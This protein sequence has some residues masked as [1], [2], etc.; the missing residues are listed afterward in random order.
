[1]GR[2]YFVPAL[3]FAVFPWRIAVNAYIKFVYKFG[4]DNRQKTG[5]FTRD[6]SNEVGYNVTNF[7]S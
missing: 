2:V 7:I 3:V 1:M 4:I 6:I 5:D